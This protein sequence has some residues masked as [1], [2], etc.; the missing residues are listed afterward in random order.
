EHRVREVED[1]E[2]REDEARRGLDP[3]E[4]AVGETAACGVG[5]RVGGRN[6]RFHRRLRLET[7][8]A[9][10]MIVTFDARCNGKTAVTRHLGADERRK[11]IRDAALR[12]FARRGYAATRME[13][14]VAE[15]G[16]SKGAI[17]WHY[18]SKKALFVDLV[19]EWFGRSAEIAA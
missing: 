1:E 2:G 14:I 5:T 15:A 8:C 4:G 16:V 7:D 18:E 6:C 12:C 17:Y 10:G 3:D 19:T 13:D 9:V 11:Q